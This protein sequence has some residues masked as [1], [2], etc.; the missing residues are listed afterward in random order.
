M[1]EQTTTQFFTYKDKPLVRVGNIMYYGDMNDP[2]VVMLQIVKTKDLKD[3]KM[4]DSVLIQLMRTDTSLNPMDMIV[5]K[6]ER[7]GMSAA[8]EMASVWLHRALS[9]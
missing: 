4:A 9:E 3:L 1:A 7:K 5:K 8:M 2:Y 6:A